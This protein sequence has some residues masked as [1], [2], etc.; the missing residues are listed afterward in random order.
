MIESQPVVSSL[1]SGPTP[2]TPCVM[3]L[4]LALGRL[5]KHAV[6]YAYGACQ[7]QGVMIDDLQIALAEIDSLRAELA[8]AR[9]LLREPGIARIA[10]ERKRQLVSEGW[11]AEHDD[12]HGNS[13]MAIAAACYAWPTPRPLYIKKAWPWDRWWWKPAI[14]GE[15]IGFPDKHT[16]DEEREARIK[17]LVRAGALI[18]AEIDRL[19]RAALSAAPIPA[20]RE[21]HD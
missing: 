14:P 2:E 7:A 5:R 6:P 12:C 19:S 17:D 20:T 4:D 13:E 15:R 3:T 1:G 18:A 16:A 10:A 21:P 11:S 9:S 8:A